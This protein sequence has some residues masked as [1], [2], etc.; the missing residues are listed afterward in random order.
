M[1][2]ILVV[3]CRLINWVNLMNRK[4]VVKVITSRGRLLG[5]AVFLELD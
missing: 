3:T 1:T 2:M 4:T 5:L